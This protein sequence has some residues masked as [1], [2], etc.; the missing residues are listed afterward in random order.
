MG[1]RRVVG[2]TGKKNKAVVA[3]GEVFPDALAVGT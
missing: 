2:I 3:S 1:A